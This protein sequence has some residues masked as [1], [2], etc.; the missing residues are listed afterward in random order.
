MS[1]VIQTPD[2]GYFPLFPS[3][4]LCI[5]VIFRKRSQARTLKSPPGQWKL[6]VI[7]NL[8]H[9]VG[10]LPHHILADLAKKHGPIMHLK[11]GQL[12]AVIISSSKAAQEVLKTHE[13]TFAQRPQVLA[14]EVMSY[15]QASIACAPYGDVWR[16]LRKICVSELLNP[17]RV[18]SFRS[19][20]EEEVQILVE[21]I[22]SVSR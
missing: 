2:L 19:I 18:Q 22:A 6:P 10:A 20:R 4:L 11:L 21:S 3:V 5:L 9:M 13:L 15:G 14:V 17:K 16:E 7:G 12:E 8:H 1:L